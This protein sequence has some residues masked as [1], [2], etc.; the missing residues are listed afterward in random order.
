MCGLY[1]SYYSDDPVRDAENYW[2]DRERDAYKHAPRCSIC[3][4]P[5]EEEVAL[6]LNDGYICNDCVLENTREVYYNYD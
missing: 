1:R 3:G 5:I 2:S 6:Y 4:E